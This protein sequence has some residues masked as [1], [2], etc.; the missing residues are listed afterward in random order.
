MRPDLDRLAQL[1]LQLDEQET[2]LRQTRQD[3]LAIINAS[4]EAIFLM[5]PDGTVILANEGLA[6]RVR[7]PVEQLPG[8]NLYSFLSPELAAARRLHV[9]HVLQTRQPH[10]FQDDRDGLITEHYLY[11]VADEAGRITHL[12]VFALDITRRTQAETALCRSRDLLNAS[13]RLTRSGG[14]EWD[15]PS[16]TLTWTE[17][18]YRLHGLAPLAVPIKGEEHIQQSLACYDVGGRHKVM[19]AFRHCVEQG[20]PYDLQLPFTAVDGRRLW[21]RTMAEPVRENGRIVK[22]IGNLVDITPYKQMEE[23]LRARLRLSE[24]TADLSEPALLQRVLDE[25]EALTGSCIGFFVFCTPDE[26]TLVPQTW[27]SNTLCSFCTT[28]ATVRHYPLATAGVWADCIRERRP[29]IHNN[30]ADL[31]HRKGLPPGHAPLCR[32]LVVPIV[33]DGRIVAAFAVGNKKQPYDQWDVELVT[34]LGD[35]AWDI[36]VRKRAEAALHAQ[37]KNYREIFNSTSEAIVIHEA[38]TGTIIDVNETALRMFGYSDKEQMLVVSVGGLSAGIPPYTEVEAALLIRRCIDEGTQVF[39]WLAQRKS[40]ET[41]WTE[42]SLRSSE[43]VGQGT[44]LAVA[45]D[46]SKRKQAENRLR[47]QADFTRRVLDS[48][49]AHIA[50]LNAQGTI[51]DV[52][53]AWTRFARHNSDGDIGPLGIGSNYFCPWSAEYGDITAAEEAFEGIRQVQRRAL[54][55]FQI[56]Y[57][58]HAPDEFRWFSLHALPL[59]GSSNDVLVSHTNITRLKQTEAQLSAALLEKE[60]LLREVHHRVKNN[61]AA[62][63]GL[64]DMQRRL[65]DDPDSRTILTELSGRIRSMSLVHEKLYRADSLARIDFHEYL[66][67]L[68]SH[69]RTS[70]GTPGTLCEVEARGVEMPLDI[71]VPC[72]MII[73]ELITNALKY[74]FPQGEPRPGNTACLI[75]VMLRHDD[76]TYTLT[77]ADN[78]IGLPPGLDWTRTRTLGMTLVRMLGQHQLGGSYTLDGRDGTALTLH[79]TPGTRKHP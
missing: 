37:E 15:T 72:G 31:P 67:A 66:L 20:V 29:V 33:R 71:A 64:M 79:F 14:W 26:Q 11:P 43:I 68:I 47:E 1:S 2:Q 36:V 23:L 69:L 77:V 28:D 78:G 21:V 57:P 42:V 41:F 73:N 50:I 59:Q 60:V 13:Q 34:S 55:S 70:F 53:T 30:Y 19:E 48:T 49:D 39:E 25:A 5:R 35:L 40:G 58:C 32:E 52:N 9:E 27:S 46:I 17:E 76:G 38:A 6:R 63:I 18:T 8:L 12:A 62:I 7:T 74:A 75:R 51:V 54:P 61:L 65:I 4:P 10:H 45:R 16:Q 56:E 24:T 3:L 44:V 22:V